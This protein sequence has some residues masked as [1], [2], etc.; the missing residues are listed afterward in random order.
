LTK[1]KKNKFIKR[2]KKHAYKLALLNKL[3]AQ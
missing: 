1:F 2:K 3:L